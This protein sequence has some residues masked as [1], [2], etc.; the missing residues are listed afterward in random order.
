MTSKYHAKR[1]QVDGLWFH[2]KGEAERWMML[3]LLEAAG[4]IG[5]LERQVRFRLE[6]NGV[7]IC[8]YIADFIYIDHGRRV[9]EDFKGVRTTEYQIKKRLMKALLN[10]DIF[11][12]DRSDLT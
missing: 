11:E 12:T 7:H 6:V 5:D 9:V 8:D 3:K 4:E 10:I 1:T 2:S